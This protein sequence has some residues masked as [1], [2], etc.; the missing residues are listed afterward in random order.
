VYSWA[1]APAP[2]ATPSKSATKTPAPT[3]KPERG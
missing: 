1:G 2:S 3:T